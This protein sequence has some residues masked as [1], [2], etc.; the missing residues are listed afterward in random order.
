MHLVFFIIFLYS[1]YIILLYTPLL[2]WYLQKGLKIT[3]FYNAIK[4]KP[5]CSF[6]KFADEVSDA[7]RAGD[8]DKNY[9]L[10]AETMKLFG[11]SAYGKTITNKEGFVNTSYANE[12][13]ITKKINKRSLLRNFYYRLNPNQCSYKWLL[14]TRTPSTPLERKP[15]TVLLLETDFQV[16]QES[17]K[18]WLKSHRL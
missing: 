3:K 14:Q 16:K 15:L 11:N 17:N 2:E 8:V 1:S 18:I 6:Q 9:D 7:R 13:D 5:S 4:Y 10:I 12:K